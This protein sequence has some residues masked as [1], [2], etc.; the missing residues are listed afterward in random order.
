M[1]EPY[2]L[3]ED[4]S[5]AHARQV[6]D[7]LNTAADAQTIADAVEFPH[8]RDIGI[9]VAQRLISGRNELNG[10]STLD[11]VY[12]VPYVGPERFTEIVVSLSGA[13]PPR[14]DSRSGAAERAD[15]RGSI[16]PLRAMLQ[17]PVQARLW[18]LQ[19]TIWL[20]QNATLL[21]QLNDPVGRALIDQPVTV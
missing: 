16:E 12:A 11:E 10:F 6:L 17:P 7:F 21:V 20:G 13:R 3:P 19:D 15:L 8:E 14:G 4:V 9:R 18:A 1:S 5:P 2:L